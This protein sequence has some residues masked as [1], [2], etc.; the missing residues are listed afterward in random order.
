MEESVIFKLPSALFVTFAA[1]SALAPPC[2]NRDHGARPSKYRLPALPISNTDSQ[3]DDKRD[4]HNEALLCPP[5][6]AD[7]QQKEVA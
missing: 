2:L 5:I 3:A 7:Y 1:D 4:C 6:E